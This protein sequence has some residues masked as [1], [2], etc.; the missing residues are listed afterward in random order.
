MN[1]ANADNPR[2]LNMSKT[3]MEILVAVFTLVMDPPFSKIEILVHT[4]ALLRA[5]CNPSCFSRSDAK[6]KSNQ[7]SVVCS[8][9]L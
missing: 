8:L 5:L 9:P 3:R 6:V 7:Y 2:R 1:W 4:H